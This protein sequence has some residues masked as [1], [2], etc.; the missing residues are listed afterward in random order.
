MRPLNT[1]RWGNFGPWLQNRGLPKENDLRLLIDPGQQFGT[2]KSIQRGENLLPAGDFNDFVPRADANT[3]ALYV[4][5][6]VFDADYHGSL[7]MERDYSANGN[8]LSISAGLD[9]Q[10]QLGSGSPIYKAGNQL[11]FDGVND[12]FHMAYDDATDLNP[13]TGD[14]TVEMW[15]TTGNSVSAYQ[16]LYDKG[17]AYGGT[18]IEHRLLI[19]NGQLYAIINDGSGT[20]WVD[21]RQNVQ[22]NT[23]YHAALVVDRDGDQSLWLN[24]VKVASQTTT[25]SVNLT[26]ER[27]FYIGSL[28]NGSIWNYSGKIHAFKYSNIARGDWEIKG[29]GLAYGWSYMGLAYPTNFTAIR[30]GFTQRLDT[31]IGGGGADGSIQ[32]PFTYTNAELYQLQFTLDSVD[33]GQILSVRICRSDGAVTNEVLLLTADPG[34]PKTYTFYF[35]KNT[36]TDHV[37][38]VL[39]NVA[40]SDNHFQIS[41]LSVRP[42]TVEYI[43]HIVEDYSK[44][45]AKHDVVYASDFEAGISEF[46][47]YDPSGTVTHLVSSEQTLGGKNTLKITNTGVTGTIYLNPLVGTEAVSGDLYRFE[48]DVYLTSGTVELT[49]A[50]NYSGQVLSETG[51]WVHLMTQSPL[52]SGASSWFNIKVLTGTAYFSNFKLSKVTGGNHGAMVNLMGQN[53]PAHP[54]G[55]LFDGVNDYVNFGKPFEVGSDSFVVFG[56]MKG[57][58]AVVMLSQK[59]GSNEAPG[60]YLFVHPTS[61]DARFYVGD[62]TSYV[63]ADSQLTLPAGQWNFVAGICDRKGELLYTYINGQMDPATFPITGFGDM[64]AAADLLF[65]QFATSYASGIEGIC[66]V[67]TFPDSQPGNWK[68]FMDKLYKETTKMMKKRGAIL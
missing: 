8:D 59:D 66:G 63:N 37:R 36:A 15:F 16:A 60:W 10:A 5:D 65:G 28:R 33:I 41:N 40:D 18:F 27:P 54:A 23:F 43:S 24:G 58:T 17:G 25:N 11:T 6:D 67:Y 3:K 38:F 52:V 12:Y 68:S 49:F 1:L 31:L 45:G 30:N 46:K 9:I 19:A 44:G 56:W 14:Y 20:S 61:F 48:A 55:F 47:K 50:S 51:K 7:G 4:F 26:N 34:T 62:G 53:Q 22:P 32:A 13:G 21:L 39:G 35:R 42:I 64:T 57:N 29:A 2:N